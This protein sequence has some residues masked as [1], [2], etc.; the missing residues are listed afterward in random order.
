MMRASLAFK[1]RAASRRRNFVLPEVTL[2]IADEAVRFLK[3]SCG[4]IDRL[5]RKLVDRDKRSEEQQSMNKHFESIAA[6]FCR[7]S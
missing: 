4:N 2:V 5:L 6:L 3:S 7:A 1:C